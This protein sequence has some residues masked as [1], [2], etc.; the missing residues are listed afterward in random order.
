MSSFRS[1]WAAAGADTPADLAPARTG[2]SVPLLSAAA[3]LAVAIA[4]S[5]WLSGPRHA[6]TA[7]ATQ[8]ESWRAM[9][10]Q[11]TEPQALRQ[12]RRLARNG[13]APAQAALGEALLDGHD[14]SL[15]NEGMRWLEA[16]AQPSDDGSGDT[17]ARFA[18]GKAL[19]LG[20]GGVARDYPRAL[21]LLRQA[22]DR[23]DAAAAYYLGLM[24]R[25]GY[26]TATNTALAAH[27]FDQ[28]ARNDI[29]AAMFMLAN[30]YRDGAGVPRDE[31]RALAL[32]EQAAGHE[33][34]EAVQALAMAYQ[35]GELGLKRDDDAF[36]Q[37]WVETAHALKHPALAP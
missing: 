9:V 4:V 6:P 25:S 19:L 3:A 2:Q 12:L 24:Y 34:P 29:P 7:D 22:A 11:A 17:R 15:R 5:G 18:L 27:W 1:A 28:A 31:A 23:G 35:N 20:T 30:A 36:Q 10:A 13:S 32:Y 8:I 33:L 16:A 14:A 21:H 37:Q 26:G